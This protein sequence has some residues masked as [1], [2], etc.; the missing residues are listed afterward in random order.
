MRPISS[1]YDGVSGGLFAP[2][3]KA[4]VGD[5]ILALQKK[6]ITIMSWAD[7][8]Y[9]DPSIPEHLASV[10]INAVQSGTPSHYTLPN[11][12]PILR[13]AVAD[14]LLHFNR[15]ET[16]PSRNILITSGADAG[17]YYALSVLIEPG[18]EVL[19][20][21]P[22]YPNNY[23][24]V[25]L[26][27][28]KPVPV[29]LDEKNG[30]ALDIDAFR[31]AVTSK[32]KA[33]VLTHPNNPTGTV[34]SRKQLE[35]L[36]ELILEKDLYLVVDQAFED[37][38]F[39]GTEFVSPASLTSMWERTITVC[40]LSKGMGLSG[41]RVGYLVAPERIMDVLYGGAVNVIGATNTLSQILAVAALSDDA[42]ARRY[43]EL[44]EQRRKNAYHILSSIPGVRISLPQA[45]FFSWI[46]VSA[47]GD[48]SEVAA[49]I[50]EKG[51]VSV[52]DGK[53]YG[54]AGHG[55]LRIVH[56]CLGSEASM[57][58]ALYRIADVLSVMPRSGSSAKMINGK[59]IGNH[60][61][62]RA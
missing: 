27:G 61:V 7:P 46:D 36:A 39:D 50:L 49:T 9:P 10:L 59:G 29:L 56:G 44:F 12:S 40:S 52:N 43:T 22:S 41:F 31:S 26:L 21:D 6:G 58:D 47:F 18:D 5:G 60:Y 20:P 16:D 1:H 38:V 28:G 13:Q 34:F 15:L 62:E 25:R 57:E 53:P 48:S 30:Y 2:V 17:L 33:V 8:F 45:G 55:H 35:N 19:V 24:D 4:D 42:F 11:G 51:K 14:K 32:T 3:T 37:S 54:N 23:V